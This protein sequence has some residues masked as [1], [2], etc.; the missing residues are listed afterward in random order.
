M[1][2]IDP[3]RLLFNAIQANDIAGVRAALETGAPVDSMKAIVTRNDAGMAPAF[4][5]AA[6]VQ[7]KEICHLLFE[8]N[9]SMNPLEN[10]MATAGMCELLLWDA[11][12]LEMAI[13]RGADPMAVAVTGETMMLQAAEV[14]NLDVIRLLARKGVSVH[15]DAAGPRGASAA[16]IFATAITRDCDALEC[17][18][19]LG[20]DINVRNARGETILHAATRP[21]IGKIP[22][23]SKKQFLATAV[24]CGL[25]I[26]ATDSLGRTAL[27]RVA[28]ADRYFKVAMSWLLALLEAG[29]N[30]YIADAAGK[31]PIDVAG[32]EC[33]AVLRARHARDLMHDVAEACQ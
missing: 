24:A 28:H 1:S 12:L 13:A 30:P 10:D 2:E 32:S 19:G 25:A 23:S 17:L 26:D 14:G 20:A 5:W 31:L 3:V 18:L 16:P 11:E 21:Y 27:Y 15:A 4:A 33:A 8:Y 7:K 22:Q 6:S 9:A 29:A